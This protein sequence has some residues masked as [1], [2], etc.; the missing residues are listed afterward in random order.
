MLCAAAALV[1]GFDNQ[2]MGV[3]AP[4]MLAEYALSPS[5]KGVILSATALG[6]FM[7][8]AI[9]GRVADYLGRR[10]ALVVSLALFGICTLLTTVA[11]DATWLF[12]ARL[13]T[14][15]GLGM[16]FVD[17]ALGLY[18]LYLW[19]LTRVTEDQRKRG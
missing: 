13:L 11:S 12:V 3:A 9:G 18:V 5:L 14:G 6:L 7:G 17:F 4:R 10:R 19:T 2:S 1:E 15:L 8:A 16:R